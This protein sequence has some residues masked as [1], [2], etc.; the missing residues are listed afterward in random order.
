MLTKRQKQ[1]LDFI[2]NYI[3]KYDYAPS[4]EEIKKHLRLSS[5]STAHYHVQTLKNMGYLKKEENQP[6]AIELKKLKKPDMLEIPLIGIIAAGE[7]IEAIESPDETI[8]IT[9]KDISKSG[10]YYALKVQ[11]N[12]MI[13]EGIFDGDIVIIKKQNNADNGQTVV[14]II[15]ENEATLKKIYKERGRVRLQPA[16]SD[17]FPVYRKEVEIRG[18][19]VKIMR[20][21]DSPYHDNKE[22]IYKRSSEEINKFFTKKSFELNKI[23]NMECLEFM[24]NIEN[25]TIDLIFAD[26]P[27]NLSKS[28]FKMKFVKSGGTD[29]NTNKGS[30]DKFAQ[31]DYEIFTKKWLSES[32]RILKKT[33]S[34]WVA[35]TYHSIYITGYL[36]EKVGFEILNEVLWHKTDATPNLSCT[37]FV[38]DHEN[39]I[40]A[41][42]NKGN[43][44]NYKQMKSINNNKQMRS[45]W[46][47]GKTT[48]GK[49]IHPT[50]K[51]E[52]LLE[53]ILLATSKPGNIVFDPFMGS[54]TTAVVAKKLNRSFLGTEIDPNYY[55]MSLE[56]LEKTDNATPLFNIG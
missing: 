29:L 31:E 13:D 1:V 10:D 16:N 14:A 37:R 56:R 18:V 8:S 53:R 7:P 36:M 54:G 33:G 47:K 15:D 24:K 27:Y 28:N 49:K 2:K 30:W 43:T 45:I 4:L 40:W 12:S 34:I 38:A 39:F 52:W 19:V 6:R 46:A 26:P 11:G 9:K 42:K 41:R 25:E 21:F 5:V 44:F 22:N 17:L 51:P 23:Y 35:G 32:L 55:K 50:Q 48:G 3:N 20:N